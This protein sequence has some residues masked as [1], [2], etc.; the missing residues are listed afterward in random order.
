M[1]FLVFFE[2]NVKVK[3]RYPTSQCFLKQ[4][5]LY[6][7]NRMFVWREEEGRVTEQTVLTLPATPGNMFP[8]LNLQT[9]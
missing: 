9:R 3:S 5:R 2:F 8:G 1:T 6:V 4:D 7:D